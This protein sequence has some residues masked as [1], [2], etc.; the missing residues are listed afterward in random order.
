MRSIRRDFVLRSWFAVLI[1]AASYLAQ[2]QPQTAIIT[3]TVKDMTGAIIPDAS[4]SLEANKEVAQ[5]THTDENGLFTMTSRPGDYIFRVAAQGF[6]TYDISIHLDDAAI[7]R[8]HVVLNVGF[9]SPCVT[10]LSDSNSLGQSTDAHPF[11]PNESVVLSGTVTDTTGAVIPQAKIT[12]E[13]THGP[14]LRTL[15][16]AAGRFAITAPPGDYILKAY[17]QGFMPYHQPVHLVPAVPVTK[18]VTLQIGI[19]FSSGPVVVITPPIELLNASLT[20]SLPLKPL[21]PIRLHT[22]KLTSLR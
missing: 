21:P 9:C 19:G 14:V 10:V 11:N 18:H 15:T 13:I 7:V 2:A 6:I 22:R 17:S 16:D 5:R 8:K 12:L 20:S 3:G 4:V 1:I